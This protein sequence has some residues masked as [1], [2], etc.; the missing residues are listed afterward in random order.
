MNEKYQV[1]ALGRLTGNAK[2]TAQPNKDGTVRLTYARTVP[3]EKARAFWKQ[4]R[5]LE[6]TTSLAKES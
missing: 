1:L 6:L 3:A 5:D 4:Q 2:I